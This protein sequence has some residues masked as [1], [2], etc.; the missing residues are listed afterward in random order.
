MA[1]GDLA[2]LGELVLLG[3]ELVEKAAVIEYSKV[4]F[5]E[6]PERI[7]GFLQRLGLYR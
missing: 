4:V 3:V 2:G 5:L 6:A 1:V 7:V